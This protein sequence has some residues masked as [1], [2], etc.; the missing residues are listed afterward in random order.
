MRNHPLSK[1][2]FKWGEFGFLVIA[3][4]SFAVPGS[5]SLLCLS[6]WAADSMQCIFTF[7]HLRV[8]P[9][10]DT[11]QVSSVT[12]FP[13]CPMLLSQPDCPIQL[14]SQLSIM[15][16]LPTATSIHYK[17]SSGTDGRSTPQVFA[18]LL[19]TLLISP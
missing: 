18:S 17:E 6:N 8:C 4:F 11:A 3:V 10:T 19:I 5:L 9:R 1:H 16:V 15:A 14:Q 12:P 13:C 7:F 2:T